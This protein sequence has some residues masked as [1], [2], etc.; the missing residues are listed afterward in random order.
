MIIFREKNIGNEVYFEKTIQDDSGSINRTIR[1]HAVT[2]QKDNVPYYV[3]YTPGMVI[4]PGAFEFINDFCSDQADNSKIKALQALKLLLSFEDLIGKRAR[5]FTAND[6]LNL[7]YFLHGYS[8]KGQ[9]IQMQLSTIRSN[10]TVNSYLAIYRKYL[11]YL[12]VDN[13]YLL[14]R[15]ESNV[16]IKI[17]D[18]FPAMKVSKYKSSEKMAKNPYLDVPMYISVDEF[19]LNLQD[20]R[21][22]YTLRDE[23]IV[24]LMYQAG[25]RIGEVLGL[26]AE[27]IKM[28]RV[29]GDYV[30][31]VFIRN[32][33]SDKPDQCAKTC[34]KIHSRAQ[35]KSPDYFVKGYGYQTVVIPQDLYDLIDEYIED[36]HF[37]ARESSAAERY[38]KKTEADSYIGADDNY[39]IFLN[40]RSTPLSSHS[41]NNV[42]RSIFKDVGIPVDTEK[43]EH[44]LNHRFRHGFAMFNVQYLNCKAVDLADRMRHKS[45]VSVYKYYRPTVSD[46]IKIKTEFTESLYEII[47]ELRR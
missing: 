29:D 15:K 19:K 16:T 7:K 39:Y 4:H 45:V 11:T 31:M 38:F 3:I 35:Y 46:Q 42:L 14:Q 25:L 24:R 21:A 20:I 41:W 36:V 8:P 13:A 17:D 18:S 28:E 33:L 32:R 34:M 10:E 27:D 47:P 37:A 23:L 9:S 12:G 6:V 22:N 30:P 2:L 26:T 44:N 5:D 40:E 43:R 1:Y